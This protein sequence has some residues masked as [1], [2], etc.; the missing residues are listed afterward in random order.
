MSEKQVDVNQ[1]LKDLFS[2][3]RKFKE[4]RDAIELLTLA[5]GYKSISKLNDDDWLALIKM[6]ISIR[7]VLAKAME[8]ENFLEYVKQELG[9]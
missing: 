8:N 4:N 5:K 3:I 6:D 2:V 7:L 9:D 1:V